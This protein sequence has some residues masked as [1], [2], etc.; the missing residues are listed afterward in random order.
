MKYKVASVEELKKVL[1]IDDGEKDISLSEGIYE[2][3]DSVSLCSNVK[4][5]GI[6]G[7]TILKGSKRIDLPECSGPIVEIDLDDAGVSDVG[8]FGLGP[9]EDFWKEYDIPKPHMETEGP[10]LQ[11]FYEGNILPLSRYPREGYLRI[12]EAL[13]EMPLFDKAGKFCGTK[14]GVFVPEDTSVF[15]QEECGELL[16]YGYWYWDWATQR[17][18]IEHFDRETGVITVKKPWHYYG[19]NCDRAD[20]HGGKFYVLNSKTAVTQPGDWCI[21][22]REKKIYLYPYPG[23]TY[24][25]ISVCENI[26]EAK[27]R[28]KIEI[29]NIDFMNLRRSAVWME[30]C[31]HIEIAD[32]K[33]KNCG[34]WAMIADRCRDVVIR[35]CRICNTGAGGIAVSGGDRNELCSGNILV[36]NNEIHD[37]AHWMRTYMPAIEANG[38]GITVRSNRIW[39]VPHFAIC[40]QGNQ[41]VIECND[42]RNAC[43]ESNDAGVIYGGCDCSCLGNVIRYNHIYDIH[44]L[45]GEGCV[46]IYFDDGFCGAEVYGNV[47]AHNPYVGV[48][49]G[50]GREIHVHDNRFFECG[51]SLLADRRVLTWGE[52]LRKRLRKNLEK[53]DYQNE[54]WK[55]AFPRLQNY[56][57]DEPWYPKYNSFTD[58]TIVGGNGLLFESGEDVGEHIRVEHNRYVKT[59]NAYEIRF[60]TKGWTC[61]WEEIG[62]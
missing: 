4:I 18:L 10:S 7:K 47:I 49:L 44:G 9:Y 60:D 51:I 15:E 35:E 61:I 50:G 19:Y 3:Y 1:E 41:H 48:L 36:E 25:D 28:E 17:H 43:F 11:L 37:I 8:R 23:Q 12:Q 30:K 45:N 5:S 40:F 24:V 31:S 13:G 38:V 2:I 57:E 34:S 22:R 32:V 58:N 26:F 56:L 46:S 59:P 52:K 14:G 27:G 62:G 55:K 33:V 20:S 16:L 21:N 29:R 53:V 54:S 42:I 6:K 39:D